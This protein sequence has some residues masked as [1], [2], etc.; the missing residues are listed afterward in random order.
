MPGKVWKGISDL[1]EADYLSVKTHGCSSHCYLLQLPTLRRESQEVVEL[2]EQESG[3]L[4]NRND[5]GLAL[6]SHELEVV[7]DAS[8]TL[9][10]EPR[11]RLVGEQDLWSRD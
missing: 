8:R 9:R 4:V 7:N 5:D 6:P 11:R 10:V 3:R 2:R 1:A